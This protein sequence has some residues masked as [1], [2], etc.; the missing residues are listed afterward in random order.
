MADEKFCKDC[1]WVR[2]SWLEWLIS[3]YRFA[4]CAHPTQIEQDD[5]YLVSGK[6]GDKPELYCATQRT[7]QVKGRCGAEGRLYEL[8]EATA[9]NVPAPTGTQ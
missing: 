1:K 7:S 8:R 9:L 2:V 6:G 5:Y 3:G 4:K